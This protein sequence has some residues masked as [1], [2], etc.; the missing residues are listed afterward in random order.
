MPAHA[1]LRIPTLAGIPPAHQDHV[2]SSWVE[3]AQDL[4]DRVVSGHMCGMSSGL[5]RI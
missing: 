4:G 3:R 2:V 5:K 1:A